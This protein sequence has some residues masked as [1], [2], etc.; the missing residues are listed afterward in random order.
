MITEVVSI[1]PDGS[2]L[3]VFFRDGTVK[4]WKLATQ[5][6][7]RSF[8]DPYT[9]TA[10]VRGYAVFSPDTIHVLLYYLDAMRLLRVADGV[11]LATFAPHCG[12]NNLRFSPDGKML[13]YTTNDGR[14]VF[15]PI[16]HLLS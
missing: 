2:H 12:G 16:G 14:A 10:G 13:C 11:C 9:V 7:I 4:I 5:T 15:E 8:Q 6:E 1:S 3:A